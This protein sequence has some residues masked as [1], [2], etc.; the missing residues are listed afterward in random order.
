MGVRLVA[1]GCR[2]L[3]R[4]C[5]TLH[6]DLRVPVGRGP[7][8]EAQDYLREDRLRLR[9]CPE[10]TGKNDAWSCSLNYIGFDIRPPTFGTCS[11]TRLVFFYMYIL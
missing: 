7:H 6:R 9:R 4:D 11:K 10:S 1:V 3:C 8:Q 2:T 5:Q